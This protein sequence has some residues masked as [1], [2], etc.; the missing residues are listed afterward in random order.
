MVDIFRI[1]F[2]TLFLIFLVTLFL[3]F[4][5]ILFALFVDGRPP[6]GLDIIRDLIKMIYGH[7]T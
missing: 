6:F 4:D 1:V 3:I 5:L 2:G 7:E